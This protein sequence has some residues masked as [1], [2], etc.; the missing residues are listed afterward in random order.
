MSSASVDL[1]YDLADDLVPCTWPRDSVFFF[2]RCEQAVQQAADGVRPGRLLDV[3]CGTADQAGRFQERGWQSWGL[4]PSLG[5]LR[6]AR[7]RREQRGQSVI[8]VRG[9]AEQ[10][11]FSDDSFDCVVCQGSLDHFARPRAF[12]AEA[13][14]ILKPDG[15]A[16]IAIANFESLSCR[17]ERN[18]HRAR[19]LLGI[20]VIKGRAYW[21]IPPNHTF[22]GDYATLRGMA[23][24]WLRLERCHGVSVLWLF[25]DWSRFVGS[26]REDVAWA[27]LRTLDRIAYRVPG[28]SDVI[29]SVWRP[30]KAALRG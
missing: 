29:V 16:I 6:L 26:L 11:P 28:L 10:I 5:M 12:M 9:I 1:N 17:L 20:P 30:N 2:W 7:L 23:R 15:R 4:E 22:K 19:K 21:Q 3:A 18:L 24:P 25:R 13:A 27:L 8:L 14:R